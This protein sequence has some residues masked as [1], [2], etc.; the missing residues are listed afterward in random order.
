MAWALTS[1]MQE[2]WAFTKEE[3]KDVEISEE[4]SACL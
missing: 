1:F 4:E 3:M 2:A